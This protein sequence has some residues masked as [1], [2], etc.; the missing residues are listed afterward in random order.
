TR[1]PSARS[2]VSAWPASTAGTAA[3]N[4]K[5]NPRANSLATSLISRRRCSG[6]GAASI[7]PD[8]LGGA[9]RVP[10][11][12]RSTDEPVGGYPGGVPAPGATSSSMVRRA[13][14]AVWDAGRVVDPLLGLVAVAGYGS[15]FE[16]ETVAAALRDGGVHALVSRTPAG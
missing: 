1:G 16:A 2:R 3:I 14:D 5:S 12:A 7:Q 11:M 13:G 15:L 9:A 10:R 6:S 4:T 8:R